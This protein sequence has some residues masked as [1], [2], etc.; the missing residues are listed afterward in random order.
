MTAEL[1]LLRQDVQ[2]ATALEDDES[3]WARVNRICDEY[4]QTQPQSV[5]SD[6][7]NLCD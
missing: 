2:I 6:A 3:L 7:H 1:M 5:K 4:M